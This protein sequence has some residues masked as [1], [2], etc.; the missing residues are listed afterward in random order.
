[1]N[2]SYIKYKSY[3]LSDYTTSYIHKKISSDLYK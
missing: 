3:E 2:K 1:M